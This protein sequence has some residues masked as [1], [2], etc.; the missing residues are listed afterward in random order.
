MTLQWVIVVVLLF[1]ALVPLVR[2]RRV[3]VPGK[4]AWG[5]MALGLGSAFVWSAYLHEKTDS[6]RQLHEENPSEEAY[7]SYVQSDHCRACHPSEY[8]SWH[9]T[10]H[11]TM[12]Q[13]A[14][15]ENVR[16]DFENV[17][18]EW[19][20]DPYRLERRGDEF[21]VEMPD[22]NIKRREAEH[23]RAFL[24]GETRTAPPA[25]SRAPRTWKRIGTMTGSHHMQAYWVPG[26][27]GNELIMFPFTYL[28]ADRKWV[29]RPDVFLRDPHQPRKWMRWNQNCIKCHT[30]AGQPGRDPRSG[31]PHSR[32]VEMGIACEACHGPAETHVRL[33]A[34]PLRRLTE[35]F[36]DEPDL[37]IINPA[38]LNAKKAS[39]V[40]G[41]CHAVRF[42]VS[43]DWMKWG[44]RYR[45]GDDIEKEQPLARKETMTNLDPNHPLAE[46]IRMI[47]EGSFWS[48]GMIRVSGREYNGLHESPCFQRGDLSCLSCHSMHQS[49]PNDQLSAGMD[50]NQACLQCHTT[51]RDRVTEHTHHPSGSSGSSCYN[52]HMPHTTY[53]LLKAMRSHQIDS[54]SVQASL[55]TGR[56]NACN[57]CHLDRSLAWT[58]RHLQDWYQ[59]PAPEL[60]GPQST[61]SAAV[62]WLLGG[63]AG[64]R[65]LIAW[66]MGWE[67]A[68][69]A[70][71]EDWMPPFLAQLLEDPY[72][73]V[74]YIAWHALRQFTGYQALDYDFIGSGD[75]QAE[76][77][78][79]AWA[80]WSRR[81]VAP[82]TD[83]A[84]V[85]MD[86]R[87]ALMED[88]FR[89]LL[90]NRN[91]RSM[92]LLE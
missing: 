70:S 2:A 74:R 87:G 23:R 66:H 5:L 46:E 4:I 21:W 36:N 48:D 71:G 62:Q 51:F 57:L 16:G 30:T 83:R 86:E 73:A 84:A 18:L 33:N 58:A 92:D 41:Q 61:E 88:R 65:A 10:F 50:G 63:D 13:Y 49:D 1:I 53:G 67:S 56:P 52:C 38:R 20:G 6:L 24:E 72:S 64:Q 77:R 78:R 25:E 17:E 31:Q 81:E 3:G 35:H 9:R 39:E 90:Q 45:P 82:A 75:H 26:E 68:R 14:H 85:L 76:S 91:D 55:A 27:S 22:P 44:W 37:S 47:W 32:V 19:D 59:I 43:G 40:C 12:T 89:E 7:E 15:P 8:E 42:N 69:S 79:E 60:S 29:P 80:L 34:N 28:F 11:R 54:P